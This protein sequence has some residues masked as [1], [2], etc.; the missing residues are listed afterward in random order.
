MIPA[1]DPAPR[2]PLSKGERLGAGLFSALLMGI[3]AAELLDGGDPRKLSVVFVVLFWY[4]L[5]V[6]HELGHALCARWLGFRVHEIVLG[7]GPELAR[8]RALG[9]RVT[10]RLIPAGGYVVPSPTRV[11]GARWRSALIYSAGPGAELL[12]AALSLLMLGPTDGFGQ[13]RDLGVIAVQSFALA[14]IMGAVSNLLPTSAAG[15]ASD[16]LGILLSFATPD[17]H[18]TY[19]MAHPTM[20]DAQRRIDA[21]DPQ[22]ALGEVETA[23]QQLPNNPF[24]KAMRARC[25]AACGDAQGA[26]TV[27]TELR[28]EP[29]YSDLVEAER[30]HAAAWIALAHG[31]REHLAQAESACRAA[32]ERA[33]GAPEF[34]ITHGAL[35]IEQ[36]R[37]LEAETQ[38]QAAYKV[39]RAPTMEDR[40]LQYL[41]A[42]AEGLGKP[43]DAKRFRDALADRRKPT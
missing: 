4:P 23:L 5:I 32:L 6:I 14:A 17:E 18:F 41:A 15:A 24:L 27:L 40:C 11:Q 35:L 28:E 30:L 37:L 3:V 29:R 21:G 25:L 20:S 31:D 7:F 43:N 26:E 39:A 36:G 1:Y 12:A 13:S 10:V 42:T 34:L 16:G 19:Q 8:V 33:P 38:L 9:A 22:A 2:R